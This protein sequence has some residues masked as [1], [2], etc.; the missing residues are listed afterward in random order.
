MVIRIVSVG[1][2]IGCVLR[3][4]GLG[5]KTNPLNKSRVKWRLKPW[6]VEAALAR[7]GDRRLTPEE[8]RE[9]WKATRKPE[10]VGWPDWWTEQG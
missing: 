2:G 8:Q 6:L 9:L 7:L 10:A 4:L 3:D 5:I 1:M